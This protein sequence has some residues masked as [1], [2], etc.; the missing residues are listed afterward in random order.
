MLKLIMGW[1]AETAGNTRLLWD[2]LD[3]LGFPAFA[4]D[5]AMKVV[6][7]NGA[8]D[9]HLSYPRNELIGMPLISIMHVPMSEYRMPP[10][11]DITV[12]KGE[13]MRRNGEAFPAR[14][15]FIR[16]S[17]GFIAVV[18]NL[19]EVLKIASRAEQRSRE[20]NTYNALSKTLCN[21]SDPRAVT[22]EVLDTLVNVMS[23]DAAWLY[24][25]DEK[26][27]DLSLWTYKGIEESVFEEARSLKPY[28]CFIGRVLSSERALLVTNACEDPRITHIKIIESGV[29]SIAGVPLIV[30]N[31]DQRG[32]KVVGVLGVGSRIPDRFSSLDM[33][34]LTSVGNQLGVAIENMRL[35][36]RLREKMKQI[37]LINEISSVVN[38]SLSIGHIFRLVVSEIKRTINFDRASINLLDEEASRLRIFAV[39]TKRPTR[40]PKGMIAPVSGTS[41]GWVALNQ[42]PWINHDL[43]RNMEFER[44]AVLLREGIRSTISVPLFKDRPLGTLNLDSIQPYQYS[45]KDLDILLPIAKHLSTALENALLFEE[46]SREKR[47]WEKTFDAI[48][49]MVWIEDMAGRVLRVNRTVSERS[50]RP[51][52]ALIHRSS[53]EI[54]GALHIMNRE[55]RPRDHAGRGRKL[56]RELN[57]FKGEVYHYWT[58]PLVDSDGNAYGVVNY[59]RDV[60]EQKRLESQL[61]RADKLASLGTLV[62]GIAHEI[63]NPLGI[64]AGYSEA[65]LDRIGEMDTES[66][67]E[68][69]DF[70]E[71]LETISR[72]I[73]RCKDILKSLL[74][75]ARP[76]TGNQREINVNELIKEVLLLVEHRLKKWHHTIDLKLDRGISK[77]KAD[78]GALRQVFINLIMNSIYFMD[79]EGRIVISTSNSRDVQGRR[80]VVVTVS[81]NGRGI[82]PE[83][84]ERV[85]DPFITTK[86]VGEGTGLGLS[87]SHRIVV[88][89]GGTIDVK[90]NEEGGSTFTIRLPAGGQPEE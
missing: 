42:K 58:Y 66:R 68:L 48:T 31:I 84:I 70:P 56:Y 71:Y 61:V 3:A 81:D 87:I 39:D 49:D 75:F 76:S 60:T 45:E 53:E 90:N 25:V 59:L 52:L 46:I 80:M 47:E 51:A 65:L 86:P 18:E 44:D 13:C 26:T 69:A 27:G 82:D 24:L 63:N 40:L 11:Q 19:S 83:I 62:A 22:R 55:V 67:E 20:I 85:F 29:K 73:F 15:T 72:E 8:V 33:K 10:G 30:K 23:V 74:D 77:I 50:G 21:A 17:E 89:H 43:S 79:E 78:P 37:E 35:I 38:S 41:S 57:G 32:G 12:M 64:I 5:E 36:E 88:D 14:F 6:D 28:E 34:F 54:F 1:V 9:T 2:V 7:A 4:V 16:R